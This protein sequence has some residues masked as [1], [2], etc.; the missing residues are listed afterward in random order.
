MQTPEDF[1]KRLREREI[2][3]VWDG[4]DET[5]VDDGF[6]MSDE[7]AVKEIAARDAE[8]QARVDTLL[9]DNARSEEQVKKQFANAVSF[10]ARA[11]KAE[12]R[13]D[14]LEKLAEDVRQWSDAYPTKIFHDPTPEEVRKVCDAVG[15][16]LDC[17]AA[18]VLREFT[19]PW[20]DQARAALEGGQR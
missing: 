12:A 3:Y 11:E 10:K 20:G 15:V 2:D 6:A 9:D 7:Y 5:K 16:P 19:K 18:M 8:W 14:R 1:A 13:V 17:I 4:E